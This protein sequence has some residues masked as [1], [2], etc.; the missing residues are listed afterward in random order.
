MQVF[1]DIAQ[2]G[3]AHLFIKT[4]LILQSLQFYNQRS[5]YYTS[6]KIACNA[7]RRQEI[8]EPSGVGV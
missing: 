5:S 3:T 2:H 7:K 8:E 1:M 6:T 4:C